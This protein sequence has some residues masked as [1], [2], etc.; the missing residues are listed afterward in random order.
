M[1]QQPLQTNTSSQPR[2]PGYFSSRLDGLCQALGSEESAFGLSGVG[3]LDCFSGGRKE[4]SSERRIPF[5]LLTPQE[6]NLKAAGR[7]ARDFLLRCVGDDFGS[8]R[9]VKGGGERKAVSEL[10]R[11]PYRWAML[12]L[13]PFRFQNLLRTITL[14]KG[15]QSCCLGFPGSHTQRD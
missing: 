4:G 13:F 1:L 8:P 10:P 6:V 9:P 12:K 2:L 5:L 11:F 7:G 15:T 14:G 3:S